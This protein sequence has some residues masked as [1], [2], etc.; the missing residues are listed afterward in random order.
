MIR[1]HR[2]GFWRERARG[3]GYLVAVGLGVL[4][5]AALVAAAMLTVMT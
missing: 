1:G 4:A 3:M 2:G 5:V